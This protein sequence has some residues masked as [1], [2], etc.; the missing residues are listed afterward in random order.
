MARTEL[1][2]RPEHLFDMRPWQDPPPP[3]S[4]AVP[5]G[6]MEWPEMAFLSLAAA[7]IYFRSAIWE[8]TYRH[9]VITDRYAMFG[10]DP[11]ISREL[12][13]ATLWAPA[14]KRRYRITSTADLRA[15]RDRPG[16]IIR[17]SRNLSDSP[18]G[19]KA[20]PRGLGLWFRIAAWSLTNGSPGFVPTAVANDLGSPDLVATLWDC[21]LLGVREDGFY[22]SKG[23][24]PIEAIWALARDDERQPIPAEL[25]Q[26]IYDRDEGQCLR[27]RATDDLCLDHI[28]PWIHC[29][30]DTF[31]N[32][33]LLC[34]SCNSSKGARY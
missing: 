23:D 20:G 1:E 15:G 13:A 29:G 25:K 24:H 19:I 26:R 22:L 33:Q 31:D 3:R 28:I 9:E 30:P 34:R 7:G 11:S 10:N 18:R 21:G 4:F 5:R 8:S 27:C 32:L 2:V 12:V 6:L 17:V 14:G 16:P